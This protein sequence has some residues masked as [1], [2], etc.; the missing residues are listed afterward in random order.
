[1]RAAVTCTHLQR[2]IDAYR[3]RFRDHGLELVLPS[4]PGQ[5]LAG[6]EL[7]AAMDGVHG[8]VA[9]DDHFTADVLRSCPDLRIIS[10]WG[11]GVDAIDHAA[12][13]AC[14]IKVTNTPGVFGDE[15][16]EMA[17]GY[18]I[19]LVRGI[20]ATDRTVRAGGWPK[21]V[22]RSLGALRAAVVGL[23]SIGQGAASKLKA[24]GLDVVA[25]DPAPASAEWA[26]ANDVRLLPLLEAATSVD[27]LVV[28]C[29]LNSATQG[30]INH[31]VIG[32]LPMGSWFVNV[33]R[34]PVMVTDAIL[35][36]LDS[37]RLAGAALDVYEVEPLADERLTSRD[38][39]ILGSHNASNTAEACAR[40][41]DRAIENLLEGLDLL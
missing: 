2:D 35:A 19:A 37:G 18:L 21:P 24:L 15:V 11:I 16:A 5:E 33:G 30:I 3:S 4:I 27:V 8:V 22:G 28:C 17:V 13:A 25:V 6:A 31:D 40:T 14:G 32:A 10:K 39:V 12:A 9:G 23:G 1:M 29:P 26:T 20:V 38:D 41:H 34:G 36:G 7:V